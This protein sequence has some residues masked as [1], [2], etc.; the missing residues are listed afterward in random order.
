MVC[1]FQGGIVMVEECGEP[2]CLVQGR[3][4][5][6]QGTEPERNWPKTVYGAQGYTSMI[7]QAHREVSFRYF[8]IQSS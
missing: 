8:L 3:P 2:T 1:W 6:E 7:S 5:A 4:E